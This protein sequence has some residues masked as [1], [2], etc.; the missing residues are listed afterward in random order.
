MSAQGIGAPRPKN[1]PRFLLVQLKKGQSIDAVL[2]SRKYT[3]FATHWDL[4]AGQKGRSQRCTK[5][6]GECDGCDR[7]LPSRWKGAIHAYCFYRKEEVFIEL[8]PTTAEALDLGVPAGEDLRGRRV[9]LKRGEKGDKT[10]VFVE[11]LIWQGNVDELPDERDPLPV[12]Q[13]LW[14]WGR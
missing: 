13:T 3:G 14:Q 4:G 2:L 8:Q 12:M 5:D 6:D 11:W 9:R 7:K 10:R 1:G